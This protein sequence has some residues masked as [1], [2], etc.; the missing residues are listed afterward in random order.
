MRAPRKLLITVGFA[1][2]LL[3]TLLA[4]LKPKGYRFRNDVA[5]MPHSGISIGPIGI[6]FSDDS[7]RWTDQNSRDSGFTFEMSFKAQAFR[8]SGTLLGFW[9]Q[10]SIRP[11]MIGQWRNR[12]LVRIGDTHAKKGFKEFGED[13]I[14]ETGKSSLI[15]IV[16]NRSTTSLYLNGVRIGDPLSASMLSDRGLQGRL[17]LGNSVTG[18]HPWSGELYGVALYHREF[19]GAEAS[20]RFRQWVSSGHKALPSAVF[21]AHFFTFSE[22]GGTVA[23]DV[24]ASGFDLHVPKLFHI[25]KKQVLLAPWDDFEWSRSYFADVVIN[26]FGFIPL[27]FFMSLFLFEV[28]AIRSWKK[29]LSLTIFICFGTSLCIELIQVYIPTRDSQ[30]SDLILNTIGGVGGGFFAKLSFKLW[31]STGRQDR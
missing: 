26:L 1:L 21:A 10:D 18:G 24:A 5:W 7:L 4:G 22:R 23:H 15:H 9:S 31:G 8:W 11:L 6:A 28:A 17:V 3:I 13:P 27:G 29:N 19:S 2:V 12:L 30:L 20:K 25:I 14:L 16:S